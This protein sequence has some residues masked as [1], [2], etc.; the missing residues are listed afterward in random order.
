MNSHTARTAPSARV[1]W[2]SAGDGRGVRRGVT[3]AYLWARAIPRAPPMRFPTII[4]RARAFQGSALPEFILV[5]TSYDK[6]IC[7]QQDKYDS[8]YGLIKYCINAEP[9]ARPSGK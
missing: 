7:V 4:E 6:F 9:A 1:A 5:M 8:C 3:P 2:R